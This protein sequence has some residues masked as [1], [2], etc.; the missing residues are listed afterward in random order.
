M[1]ESDYALL[2]AQF[3]ALAEGEDDALAN[4]SNFVGLL[5]NALHDIQDGV[6][7]NN[8]NHSNAHVEC[9]GHLFCGYVTGLLQK[10][11]NGRN[12]PAFISD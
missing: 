10:R 9:A 12:I 6:V 11:K 7:G 8:Q 5:F 4:T 2:R 3:D 1:N